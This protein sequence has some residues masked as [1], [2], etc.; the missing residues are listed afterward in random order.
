MD[1]RKYGI[2]GLIHF[3]QAVSVLQAPGFLPQEPLAAESRVFLAVPLLLPTVQMRKPRHQ[4][5]FPM[6]YNNTTNARISPKGHLDLLSRQEVAS[7]L[8][9]SSGTLSR[10][11]RNCSLAV[12]NYDDYQVDD[13]QEL[14]DRY[15]DYEIRGALE[16]DRSG[17][18]YG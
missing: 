5:D 9:V 13:D 1:F 10:V 16:P 14:M 15:P 3:L 7:L 4:K 17:G 6:P 8:E 18:F 2:A 12:L 11:F